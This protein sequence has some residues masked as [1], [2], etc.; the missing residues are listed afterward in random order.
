MQSDL[1][2]LG[3]DLLEKLLFQQ[4]DKS[5]EEKEVVYFFL[6]N[7]ISFPQLFIFSPMIPLLVPHH[8]HV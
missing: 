1:F 5:R 2:Q 7:Y 6:N 4:D 8:W 3:N